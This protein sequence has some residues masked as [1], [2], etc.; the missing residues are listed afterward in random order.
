MN[1][2]P[3]LTPE[4]NTLAGD[5]FRFQPPGVT[6]LEDTGLSQLWLQ[7][8]AL[9]II[10]FQGF[11]TGFKVAEAIALPFNGIVDQLLESLK[12]EKFI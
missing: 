5:G 3:A 10:Y 12:R 4:A 8:L 2:T 7:E 11:L 9:K 6:F 1:D